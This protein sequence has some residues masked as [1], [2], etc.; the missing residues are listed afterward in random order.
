ML[1]FYFSSGDLTKLQI[2]P[3]TKFPSKQTNI[4]N[5]PLKVNNLSENEK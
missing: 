1:F 2:N 5:K 4:N 3:P